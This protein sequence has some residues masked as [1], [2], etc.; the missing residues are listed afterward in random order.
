MACG[1]AKRREQIGAII[2]AT[3]QD[4]KAMQDKLRMKAELL[5]AKV[6]KIENDDKVK[7]LQARLKRMGGR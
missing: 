1:C 5:A 4:I 2:M 3:K 6:R 7:E